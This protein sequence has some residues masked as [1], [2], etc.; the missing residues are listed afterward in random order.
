MNGF[1]L[2]LRERFIYRGK[3]FRKESVKLSGDVRE[4]FFQRIDSR[5]LLVRWAAFVVQDVAV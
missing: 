4:F 1:Y 3:L 5:G 2:F